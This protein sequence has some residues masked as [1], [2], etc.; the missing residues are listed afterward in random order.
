MKER[1]NRQK[2]SFRDSLLI[3]SGLHRWM[4]Q[5]L[6]ENIENNKSDCRYYTNC[7]QLALSTITC[8]ERGENL[9]K[10]NSHH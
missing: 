4:V 3:I 5:I 9:Y 2:G 6:E 10:K 1:Q 7:I 8:M